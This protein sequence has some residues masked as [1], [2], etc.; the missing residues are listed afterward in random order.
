MGAGNRARQFPVLPEVE[1]L[2]DLRTL[3]FYGE[4]ESESLCRDMLPAAMNRIPLSGGHHFGG[5]YEVIARDILQAI[6]T[7][8]RF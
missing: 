4:Q 2:Q 7:P 6:E 8:W 5:Q 1:K 3:C